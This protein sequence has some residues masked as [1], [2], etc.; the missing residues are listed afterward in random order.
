[1]TSQKGQVHVVMTEIE[2]AEGLFV[3]RSADLP[4]LFMAYNDLT[5]MQD[6]LPGLIAR[7]FEDRMGEPY[8]VFPAT[9]GSGI[10][11]FEVK[12]HPWTAIPKSMVSNAIA[13]MFAATERVAESLTPSI[14]A[15]A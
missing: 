1:M 13:A 7:I 8:L 4:E 12:K 14:P 5:E 3:T 10:A 9:M 15:S 6:D 11:T 2:D